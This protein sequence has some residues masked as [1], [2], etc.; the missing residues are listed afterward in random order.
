MFFSLQ[1]AMLSQIRKML[2]VVDLKKEVLN[3]LFKEL[4]IYFLNSPHYS[5]SNDLL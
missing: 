5:Y 4:F 3:I 2:K 1:L